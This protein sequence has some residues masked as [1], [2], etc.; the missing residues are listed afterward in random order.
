ME[1]CLPRERV[2]SQKLLNEFHEETVVLILNILDPQP[3][4]VLGRTGPLPR[5]EALRAIALVSPNPEERMPPAVNLFTH[6]FWHFHVQPKSFCTF[7]MVRQSFA[8]H[9]FLTW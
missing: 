7:T 5:N 8:S 1:T 4:G 2:W 6:R 3:S 9:L